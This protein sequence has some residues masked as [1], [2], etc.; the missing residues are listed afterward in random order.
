[1]IRS[2]GVYLS[3]Y[4]GDYGFKLALLT[5]GFLSALKVYLSDR[6]YRLDLLLPIGIGTLKTVFSWVS[7]TSRSTHECPIQ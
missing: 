3:M 6:Q 7:C 4:V 2:R 5:N 1:M